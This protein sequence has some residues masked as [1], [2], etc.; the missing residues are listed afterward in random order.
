[1]FH[2]KY[3]FHAQTIIII[4]IIISYTYTIRF[5]WAYSSLNSACYN[6]S[7]QILNTLNFWQNVF[8]SSFRLLQGGQSY[9]RFHHQHTPT[10][11]ITGRNA[12][13]GPFP[14]RQSQHN[15]SRHGRH[16]TSHVTL[17]W[18]RYILH[19]FVSFKPAWFDFVPFGMKQN[20]KKTVNFIVSIKL[21]LYT[22]L[23]DNLILQFIFPW[24]FIW[25]HMYIFL[26]QVAILGSL[27]SIVYAH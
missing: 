17:Q 18:K 19:K 26:L 4:I 27:Y 7:Q 16:T 25:K 8:R 21:G 9:V 6:T 13:C 10:H 22:V 15:S 24:D 1:M 20:I 12:A 2:F 14:P 23:Y 11:L 5:K 3:D